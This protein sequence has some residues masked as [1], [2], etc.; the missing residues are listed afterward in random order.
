MP[1]KVSDKLLPQLLVFDRLL[2]RC[3]PAVSLPVFVPLFTE[4]I[5]QIR[6]VGKDLNGEPFFFQG[7]ERL[8]KSRHFHAV[9]GRVQH[10]AVQLLAVVA[11]FEHGSPAATF[12]S[13]WLPRQPPSVYILIKLTKIS[14]LTVAAPNHLG[15]W[16]LPYGNAVSNKLQLL[17]HTIGALTNIVQAAADRRSLST[18]YRHIEP[19]NNFF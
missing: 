2:S 17:Y 16:L 9:V 6:A 18:Q 7:I 1:R 15:R 11:V 13:L 12:S 5:H 4:A 14:S 8:E 19:K 3:F 10:A